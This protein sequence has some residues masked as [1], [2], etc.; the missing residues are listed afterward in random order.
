MYSRSHVLRSARQI[1]VALKTLSLHFFD[2]AKLIIMGM[3]TTILNKSNLASFS[4]SFSLS[5]CIRHSPE[6]SFS[7]F[8]CMV[9]MEGATCLSE[10]S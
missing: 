7:L 4:F 2:I 10:N 8:G 1:K 9:K 3:S 6:L 5:V